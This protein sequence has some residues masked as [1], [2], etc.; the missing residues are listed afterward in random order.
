MSEKKRDQLFVLT[1]IVIS[2]QRD[3]NIQTESTFQ[4]TD[5]HTQTNTGGRIH[6]FVL[7]SIIISK[8]RDTE[9]SK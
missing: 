2:K 9:Y 7:T 8:Q 4:Q 5:L 3:I 1:Y 6:L